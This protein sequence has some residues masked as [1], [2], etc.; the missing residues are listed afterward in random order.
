MIS[1]RNEIGFAA[2]LMKIKLQF[3][4]HISGNCSQKLARRNDGEWD[5]K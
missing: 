1:N 4:K 5:A 3:C 2:K